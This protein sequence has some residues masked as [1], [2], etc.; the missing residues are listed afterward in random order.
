MT[1]DF[2]KLTVPGIRAELDA[3]ADD[4]RHSFGRL[5]DRQFNW[6]EADTSWS[7][8]QCVEHLV[9]MN[10]LMS[11]AMNDA[12]EGKGRR[13]IAQ[14]LPLVPAM[15]GRMLVRSQSPVSTRRFKAPPSGVPTASAIDRRMLD[16][17]VDANRQ[18]SARLQTLDER[19]LARVIMVSPFMSFVAYSVLDGWRLIAAHNWRHVEQARRV[20]R[21]PDFPER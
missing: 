12:L 21:L 7:V 10:R 4:A 18:M 8:A 17:F 9:T 2:T 13:A 1:A 14:R 3:A 15:F 11:G 19:E 20:T 5:D 6:R 16:E